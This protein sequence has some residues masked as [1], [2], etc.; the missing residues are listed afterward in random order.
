MPL[1]YPPLVDGDAK[2]QRDADMAWHNSQC[3]QC[4]SSFS[5][6]VQQAH[7]QQVRREFAEKICKTIVKLPTAIDLAD[8]EILKKSIRSMAEEK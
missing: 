6:K 2:A 5:L 8:M 7:D 1:I 4:H 3:N